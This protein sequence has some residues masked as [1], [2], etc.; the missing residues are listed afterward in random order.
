MSAA[1]AAAA[2]ARRRREQEEEEMTLMNTDPSGATEYKIIRSATGAF[3]HPDKFRAAL[4]EEARAGWEL[5]EKFDNSRARLRRSIECR[6]RD[7]GLGHDP[8][9]TQIGMS[10]AALTVAIIVYALLGVALL[11][12]AVVSVVHLLR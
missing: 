10:E 11:I 6:A 5:A 2:A 3:K 7:A 8:Y 12:G 9:R 4:D 1:A